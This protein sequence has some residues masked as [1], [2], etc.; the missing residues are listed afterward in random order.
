M[1]NSPQPTEYW[2]SA[3]EAWT[4]NR[5]SHG[6]KADRVRVLTALLSRD[7]MNLREELLIIGFSVYCRRYWKTHKRA[8]A[9]RSAKEKA[10]AKLNQAWRYKMHDEIC[11]KAEAESRKAA[12]FDRIVESLDHLRVDGKVLGDCCRS[13]L[14]KAAAKL[15]RAAGEITVHAALYRQIAKI[16]GS[17]TVREASDRGKIVA[18]LTTTF[19]EAA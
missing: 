11:A 4:R 15:E 16:I 7:D 1:T 14:L 9:T 13:D 19:K 6:P 18:L 3:I 17:G 12:A 8:P 2:S 10:M 5:I